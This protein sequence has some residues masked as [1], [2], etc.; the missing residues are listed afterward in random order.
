[1]RTT[2]HH[3][4]PERLGV[5]TPQDS[6]FVPV[7]FSSRTDHG[8]TVSLG[9]KRRRQEM[10][11]RRDSGRNGLAMLVLWIAQVSSLE[12]RGPEFAYV[13]AKCDFPKGFL[14]FQNG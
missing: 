5:S 4:D 2:A 9:M 3:S 14:L 10:V 6:S 1:M 12:K 8:H 11:M 13:P 7:R